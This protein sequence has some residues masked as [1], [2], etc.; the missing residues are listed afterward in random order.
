MEEVTE[1][2]Q[3]MKTG[4]AAGEDEIT[5]ELIK[6]AGI[7]AKNWLLELFQQ[8]WKEERIPKNWEQNIII[9]IHK[10]G[11]TNAETIE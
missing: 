4:K 11:N 10:E 8:I 7:I 2:I 5:P 9:P 6:Y 1:A 3:N